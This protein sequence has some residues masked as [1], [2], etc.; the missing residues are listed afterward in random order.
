MRYADNRRLPHR[1]PSQQDLDNPQRLATFRQQQLLRR[2]QECQAVIAQLHLSTEHR[3]VGMEMWHG[4]LDLNRLVLCGAGLG[5]ATA[6]VVAAQREINTG[7]KD[8][9]LAWRVRAIVALD[10]WLFAVP[11]DLAKVALPHTPVLTI[12]SDRFLTERAPHHCCPTAG[13]RE[14]SDHVTNARAVR[15]M[16][17]QYHSASHLI[18][19]PH[20]CPLDLTDWSLFAP[21]YVHRPIHGGAVAGEGG[22]NSFVCFSIFS[23]GRF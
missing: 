2:V 5:A 12:C 14:P 7:A 1:H 18:T 19:L 11:P 3:V 22:V 20:T 9:A 23:C 15:A 6:C 13:E 16:V 10:P 8:H 17:A 21:W 4:R